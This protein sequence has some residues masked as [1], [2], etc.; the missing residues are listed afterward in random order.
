MALDPANASYDGIVRGILDEAGA[1]QLD[2]IELVKSVREATGLGLKDAKDAV[3]G[4][5]RRQASGQP[6]VRG[7]MYATPSVSGAPR[8]GLVE[9]ILAGA[10]LPE[11]SK[12]ELIKRVREATGLGLKEAK[13]A[14]EGYYSRRAGQP[15]AAHP[16]YT[17]PSGSDAPYD[18]LIDGMLS[19]GDP[20]SVSNIE[21][22]KRVREATG[23]GL[24]DAKDAVDG[25]NQ[26]HGR[27]SSSRSGCAG[28][29]ALLLAALGL[30]LALLTHHAS[31]CPPCPCRQAVPV[32]P[33]SFLRLSPAV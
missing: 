26:R 30:A 23:L 33:P 2:K 5:Y 15:Q 13:D 17:A 28:G 3:D 32:A 18:A 14:V 7:L 8:D 21:L 20:A 16:L 27:V 19:G 11:M 25:Y 9:G 12:I 31:P 10:G 1:A 24:K 29:T 22:I 4:Y 6:P